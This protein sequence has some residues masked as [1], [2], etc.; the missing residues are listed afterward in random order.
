MRVAGLVDSEVISDRSEVVVEA[1]VEDIYDHVKF[2][3]SKDSNQNGYNCPVCSEKYEKRDLW[4]KHIHLSHLEDFS[5]SWPPE[6]LEEKYENDSVRH[7]SDLDFE[8]DTL[9]EVH[10]VM[11]E[12]RDYRCMYEDKQGFTAGLLGKHLIKSHPKEV[13]Y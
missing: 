13:F 6:M 9:E 4:E 3:N 7:F 11:R 2:L 1:V 10:D 12:W 5:K 8:Q